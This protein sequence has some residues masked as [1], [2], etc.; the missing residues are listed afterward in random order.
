MMPPSMAT[1]LFAAS[2]LFK[3]NL[4]YM[5]LGIAMAM[6]VGRKHWECDGI[7]VVSVVGISNP[8]DPTVAR[9]GIVA[10]DDSG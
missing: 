10:L 5:P 6:P 2:P 3:A 4:P 7:T 9:D 8:I 1:L